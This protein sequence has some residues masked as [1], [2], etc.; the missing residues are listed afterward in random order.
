MS[1]GPAVFFD[2]GDTLASAVVEGAHLARLDVYPF[3]PDVL[4]RMREGGA[5]VGLISNTGNET[6][7]AMNKLLRES[8][9]SAVVDSELCLFSSLEGMNKSQP[10]FFVLASERAGLPAA[11][12]VFVGEDADE[13]RTA[14]TVGFRVSPHPLHALHLVAADLAVPPTV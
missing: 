4:A 2:I 14:D 13:R 1:S 12:C 3:V 11:R 6:A 7:A 10:S 9:L 5:G 8:G